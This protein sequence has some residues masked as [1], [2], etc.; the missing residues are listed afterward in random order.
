MK[1]NIS[2]ILVAGLLGA[3]VM[4]LFSGCSFF[5]E[6]VSRMNKSA[7][8]LAAEGSI[9][10]H[11][12]DYHDAVKAYMDL[13]D[14]YPFSKYAILAELKI[15]DSYFFLKEYA[16]A[17][18]AYENFERLHPRNEA[19]PYVISQMGMCWFKQIDTIDRDQTPSKN[20]LD[21][22]QRL[23]EKFPDSPQAGNARE[24]IKKCLENLAGHDLYIANYYAKVKKYKAALHRYE[25]II[26][27]YPGTPQSREAADKLALCKDRLE[28]E[29]K[30]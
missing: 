8:Q 7:E 29:K 28:M 23:S 25:H 10:F 2:S 22:F 19:V 5:D 26:A 3:L 1:K 30:E 17:V 20:A 21:I 6:E 13:R 14:W 9:A 24:Y 4:G 11:N 27:A 16:Q 18:A 15:A 12:E